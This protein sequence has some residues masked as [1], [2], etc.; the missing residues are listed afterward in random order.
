MKPGQGEGLEQFHQAVKGEELS[1]R[2]TSSC[3]NNLSQQVSIEREIKGERHPLW[4]RR[5]VRRGDRKPELV[6]ACD[7]SPLPADACWRGCRGLSL[8]SCACC[9]F[10]PTSLQCVR[11][12]DRSSAICS[13]CGRPPERETGFPEE[14]SHGQVVSGGWSSM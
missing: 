7:I 14:V 4:I 6:C 3:Y 13:T 10:P 9:S 12:L 5:S 8:G 1:V 2:L 11:Q